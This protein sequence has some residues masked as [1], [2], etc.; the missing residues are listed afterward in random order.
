MAARPRAVVVMGVIAVVVAG[1]ASIFLYKYLKVQEQRVKEAVATKSVVVARGAIPIGT[2]INIG[3]V[4]KADWP[5][6]SVPSGAF[7]STDESL[8]RVSLMTIQPGD[9]IT[10]SKLVP[11]EGGGI[12]SYRIPEGHRAMTVAVDK[13]S[14]V[15]GFISP[16]N[17]VDVIVTAQPLNY[18]EPVGKIFLQNVPVLATGKIIEQ[19]PTG[20]PVEVPTVTLDVAPEDAEKLALASAQGKLQLILRRAGDTK[21]AATPGTTVTKIVALTGTEKRAAVPVKKAVIR[22]EGKGMSIEIY[23]GTQKS[24]ESFK[25]AE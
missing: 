21:T 4:T 7:I 18:K 24:T 11:K 13:V 19:K 15:A 17:M 14:G 1:I 2:V 8:G 9:P 25:A 20:E 3:H 10:E 5:V 16:G 12:L 23:R 6:A 22:T